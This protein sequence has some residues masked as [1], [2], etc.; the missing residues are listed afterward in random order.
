MLS[1]RRALLIVAFPLL[2][3][4]AA[5]ACGGSTSLL[6]AP[7]SPAPTPVPS[8]TT[9]PTPAAGTLRPAAEA[10]FQG[11]L[12]FDHVVALAE[13]IGP[14]LAGSEGEEEAARYILDVLAEQ[15]Y[16]ASLQP[17][18]FDVF[19]DTGSKLLVLT[20]REMTVAALALEP[21]IAG[22]VEGPLV[23]A[24]LGRPQ[25]FP[26]EAAGAIVLMER[27]TLFFGEKVAN[28]AAAGAAGAVIFNDEPGPFRGL[29]EGPS[30]IPAASISRE[31]GLALRALLE[32]GP[33]QVRL[34]VR[35]FSGPR[36]SQNVVARPPGGEC[37]VVVGAHYD[38]VA[39]G[40]GANDNASGTATV[41]EM[42]R[43]LAADGE[44]EDVCF[45]LFGAEEVG[46]IGSRYFVGS[47]SSEGRQAME[48]M[49]NFDM[50]GVGSRW[51]FVGSPELRE[52][53]SAEAER[54]G[55]A[56]DLAEELPPGLGSDHSSFL[57]AG[58]PALFFH[59]VEDPFYHTERDRADNVQP[60]QLE[61]VGR[62]GLAIIALLLEGR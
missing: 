32:E 59:R 62:L 45:A 53:L 24:G 38:S 5:A 55:L 61:E 44:F 33:V 17:F 52:L 2:L 19:V 21:S 31:D 26:P 37:R 8:P 28:A 10:E 14:R 25:D 42:A 41:L 50:V 48:A 58:I 40:P 9:T 54:Q 60:E 27:G 12:A 51:F 35:A 39:A 36:Q 4:A 22:T 11:E 6:P 30:N 13:G 46:L 20:P 18:A 29:M 34:E 23:F 49:L 15:G 57:E 47:L 43:A 3:I 1:L 56:F 16:E 7:P